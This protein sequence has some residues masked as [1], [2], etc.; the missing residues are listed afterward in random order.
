MM[1]E[2]TYKFS[3]LIIEHSRAA[4]LMGF[5]DGVLSE[6]FSE[7]WQDVLTHAEALCDIRGTVTSSEEITFHEENNRI[8]IAGIDFFVGKTL[9]KELRHSESIL[10]F[11]CTAGEKISTYSSGLSKRE[12]PLLGYFYDVLGSLTVEAAMD[13]IH[14]EIKIQAAKNSKEITNRYSPG[15][16]QWNVADQHKLFSFFNG[17][18]SGISLTESALMLPAKSVS[19]IIGIGRDVKFRAYTCDLCNLKACIY[20]N[21]K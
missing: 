8:N 21:M 2:F 17:N 15:Y 11:V 3:E 12:D 20:R 7:Y 9:V 14:H 1:Q 18:S 13:K 19:G 4:K 10:F 16:C 5:A 6:P